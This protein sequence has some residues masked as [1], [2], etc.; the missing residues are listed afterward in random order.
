MTTRTYINM[1]RIN[2][3]V[4]FWVSDTPVTQAF[5][6]KVMGTNPSMYPGEEERPVE[7]VSW[8]VIS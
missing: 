2:P 3:D 8:Y 5:Y 4:D 6:Q 1:I 7:S